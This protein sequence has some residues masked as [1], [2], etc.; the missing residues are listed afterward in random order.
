MDRVGFQAAVLQ[1][2][3]VVL[4]GFCDGE[5]GVAGFGAAAEDAGIGL[6]IG[7]LA[8][9]LHLFGRSLLASLLL[10]GAGEVFALW[11]GRSYLVV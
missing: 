8:A 11:L 4:E 1:E 6:Y 9:F 3:V 5:F 2:D 7:E 10:R